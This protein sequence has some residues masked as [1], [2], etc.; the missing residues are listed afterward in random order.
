MLL[1]LLFE[2]M[3]CPFTVGNVMR[4]RLR[5]LI[6]KELICAADRADRGP[7]RDDEVSICWFFKLSLDESCTVQRFVTERAPYFAAYINASRKRA[8]DLD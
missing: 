5:E 3:A 7:S 8:D 6:E 4:I 1:V 2:C